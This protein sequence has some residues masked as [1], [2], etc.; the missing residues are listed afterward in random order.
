T[1]NEIAAPGTELAPGQIYDIN[2]FTL[3]AIVSEHG[4][5]AVP[6]QTAQDTIDDLNLA[7]D[8]CLESDLI[9]FSGGSSVGERDLTLDIIGR[10]GEIV[11]HG[12][13]L[14][15]GK[16]TAFGVVDGKPVFGMPGYPPS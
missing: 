1:G 7:I 12:I 14:K 15:P 13:S 9:V 5:I 3:S 16:P 11:F 6:R 10:R 4:G 8:R 2:R